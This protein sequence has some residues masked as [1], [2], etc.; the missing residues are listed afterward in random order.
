[1]DEETETVDE[2]KIV[3]REYTRVVEFASNTENETMRKVAFP[4]EKEE[5]TQKGFFFR[6]V[7]GLTQRWVLALCSMEQYVNNPS[8]SVIS[9]IH[10]LSAKHGQRKKKIAGQNAHT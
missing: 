8:P 6:S 1:M 7:G 4:K 5:K 10:Q 2:N 9:T 3:S